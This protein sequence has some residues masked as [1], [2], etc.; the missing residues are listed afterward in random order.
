MVEDEPLLRELV[1][2]VLGSALSHGLALRVEDALLGPDQHA[3]PHRSESSAR[4]GGA[5]LGP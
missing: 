3:R 5:W 4:R 1:E 2:S